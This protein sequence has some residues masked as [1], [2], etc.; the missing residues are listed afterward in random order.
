MMA[1]LSSTYQPLFVSDAEVKRL[2]IRY[3][4]IIIVDAFSRQ[5]RELFFIDNPHY[6]GK[7][8]K[9]VYAEE[10]FKKYAAEKK[11]IYTHFYYPWN[12]HMVK[13]VRGREYFRLKTNRNQDLITAAEQE[14]LAR[15]RVAVFGM[16]VGS[17]IAFVLTQA[18]ISREITIADF[19]DLDTTN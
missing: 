15:Y 1:N 10:I 13:T 19:D 3:P 18:G 9:T 7:H 17:N 4:W 2:K 14:K 12:G 6:T 11:N 8:K 5:I 16:S